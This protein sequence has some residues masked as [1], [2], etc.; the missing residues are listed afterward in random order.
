MLRI[1]KEPTVES[2]KVLAV[3]AVKIGQY[4]S[5]YNCPILS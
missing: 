1:Q 2:V 3:C 4:A 5:Q